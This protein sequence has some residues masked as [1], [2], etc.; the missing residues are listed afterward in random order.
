MVRASGGTWVQEQAAWLH[1][2]IED[3]GV[4][5]DALI[6]LGVPA[7]VV[8]IVEYLTHPKGESNADYWA[9]I[10]TSPTALLVKICDVHDNLDPSRLCYLDQPTQDRLRRKY[11][12]AL[13]ALV[14]E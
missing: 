2:V 9:R 6:S 3:A 1:D 13:L 7:M 14:D 8:A 4:T 11:A 10:K 12:T 5:G